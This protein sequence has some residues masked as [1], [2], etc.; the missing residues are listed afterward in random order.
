MTTSGA[1]DGN[2]IES[3]VFPSDSKIVEEILDDI[4]E[5]VVTEVCSDL[6]APV[7]PPPWRRLR[8]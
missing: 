4:I 3:V 6:P 8:H 2:K 1:L 7:K 5:N